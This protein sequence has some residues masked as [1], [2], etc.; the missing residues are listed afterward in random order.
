MGLIVEPRSECAQKPHE[1]LVRVSRQSN[2]AR[3]RLP[4]RPPA[5]SPCFFLSERLACRPGL[6]G[7][8]IGW[9]PLVTE[10]VG[11]SS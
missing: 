7:P 8:L 5:S 1:E 11:R 3:P 2:A 10:M 6:S 9:A 4:V